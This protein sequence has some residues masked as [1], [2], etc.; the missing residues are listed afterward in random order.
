MRK[1]SSYFLSLLLVLIT[2]S[3]YSATQVRAAGNT[4]YIDAIDGADTNNGTSASTAW[5]SLEFLNTVLDGTAAGGPTIAA[6][7]TFLFKRGH[8]FSGDA[9]TGGA[10]QIGIS[11]TIDN[12]I[13]FMDYGS[14]SKPKI[15]APSNLHGI[16]IKDGASDIL[17]QNIDIQ[18]PQTTG[19]LLYN[20]CSGIT[21]RDSSIIGR[22]N[23]EDTSLA[24]GIVASTG[25]FTGI[26]VYNITTSYVSDGF[27]AHN[28]TELAN[29][30]ISD[31]TF[32]NSANNGIF[33]DNDGSGTTSN[34]AINQVDANSNGNAGLAL[35][36][37]S[38]A[39]IR[40]SKFELNG[41][42]GIFVNDSTYIVIHNVNGNKNG[43]S[44][45]SSFGAG[46]F[47]AN[48]SFMLVTNSTFNENY[49]SGVCS[50]SR[51][52]ELAGFNSS[53]SES[54]DIAISSVTTNSNTINGVYLDS[55]GGNL[56]LEN[57]QS[58]SNNDDGIGVHGSWTNI[59]ISNCLLSAN[60][61]SGVSFANSSTGTIQ[62]CRFVNNLKSGIENSGQSATNIQNNILTH[63]SY[64]S[65]P[66]LFLTDS[67]VH[68][69][70]HNTIYGGSQQ[71]HGVMVGD[72]LADGNTTT[73]NFKDN[74]VYGFDTGMSITHDEETHTIGSVVLV[75]RKNIF[76]HSND[77]LFGIEKGE[78]STADPLFFGAANGDFNLKYNSPAIDAAE[79]VGISVDF[80]GATRQDSPCL[81]NTGSGAVNYYDIGALEF[82]YSGACSA[83]TGTNV[84]GGTLPRTGPDWLF[85]L[86][87][88]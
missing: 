38:E 48:T 79:D 21:I 81:D 51:S 20:D 69:V 15:S 8:T 33:L 43:T 37:I 66:L 9:A 29:L 12:P 42:D 82:V 74:I 58:A 44:E 23:A 11:G 56:N 3:S 28:F 30:V 18:G 71:G 86:F 7:D 2:V 64:G 75:Q 88:R 84:A 14:G 49:T 85:R 63:S 54:T 5:K 62:N 25:T 45:T 17:I 67:G 24:S 19:I 77:N 27:K 73:V 47:F 35:Y 50:Q 52:S 76:N 6:G 53:N 60:A 26:S 65:G 40:S 31:S 36:K 61:A 4:Y 87:F 10:L 32:S 78:S 16:V 34:L 83:T 72:Y 13:R 39:L 55:E 22:A 46:L 70:Y 68:N 80:T 1:I 59:M 57:I 41:L